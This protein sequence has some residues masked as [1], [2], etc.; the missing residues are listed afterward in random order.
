MLKLYG[1]YMLPWNGSVGAY[2]IYQSGQ[3]YELWS[4]LPY[5]SLT[6]STSDTDRFLERAGSRKSPAHYQTDL[7]YTQ[8]IGVFRGVN[9]QLA[10]DVF[11]ALNKQTGYNYENRLGTLGFVKDQSNPGPDTIQ[12]PYGFINAPYPRFYFSPRRVQ[13]AARL[14]F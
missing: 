10:A 12:T 6:D 11:N 4:Y 14:N 2:A 3:P 13:I 7:N 1:A 5:K 9:V 8:N